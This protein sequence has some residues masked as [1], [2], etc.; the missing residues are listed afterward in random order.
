MHAPASLA[1]LESILKKIEH[2]RGKAPNQIFPEIE[3]E[4]HK[5]ERFL[6]D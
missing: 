1:E 3:V 4:L 6:R 2:K 5:Q